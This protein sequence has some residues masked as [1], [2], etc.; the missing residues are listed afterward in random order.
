MTYYYKGTK[1]YF[2]GFIDDKFVFYINNQVVL[3]K[4]I[5]EL[6]KFI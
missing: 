2:M 4:T 3:I 6:N 1:V 5:K